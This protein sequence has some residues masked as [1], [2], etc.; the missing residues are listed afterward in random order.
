MS[1]AL[2]FYCMP[3]SP[4]SNDAGFEFISAQAPSNMRGLLIGIFFSIR[5]FSSLLSLLLQQLFL[6]APVKTHTFQA[7]GC[8]FWFYLVLAGLAIIAVGLYS[9]IACKYKRRK[10]DDLFN[11]VGMLEEYYFSTLR[12]T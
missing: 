3:C 6:W 10:R 8:A 9:V 1:D 4:S 2:Y 5:D 7:F 11:T 12:Q